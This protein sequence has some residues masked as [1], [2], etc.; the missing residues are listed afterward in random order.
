MIIRKII[1][2]LF[3]ALFSLS[4]YSQVSKQ[5]KKD[6]DQLCSKKMMGRGYSFDGDKKADKYISGQLKKMG[7]QV[8]HH[9]FTFSTNTFE[10]EME[11]IFEDK[12]LTPGEDF[13]LKPNSPSIK[14]KFKLR[15]LNA[16]QSNETLIEEIKKGKSNQI[17]VFDE[18]DINRLEAKDKNYF[19]G[20][21]N[22]LQSE[23]L[24]LCKAIIVQNCKK[25]TFS[26]SQSQAKLP[27]IQ[28][29][30]SHLKNNSVIEFD[31]KATFKKNYRSQNVFAKIEG[32]QTDSFYIFTAHYDHLGSL[33]KN[34]YF[35]GANDNAS[36]TSFLLDLAR[37]YSENKPKHSIYFI[38]FSGEE[39]GLLGSKA[40]VNDE[41]LNLDNLKFLLNFD[42]LGT[43]EDGIQ[44][45]NSTIY[46]KEY[47]VLDSINTESKLLK[48]LKRRGAA[49]NSDHCPFHNNGAKSFF[50][51]T[52]GGIQ[53]YHDVFDV[54][55]TL[56]LTEFNDVKTL[57]TKF[58]EIN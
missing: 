34:V 41:V 28:T 23:K 31:I 46:K 50:I 24:G 58:I 52:L 45:V 19:Y 22:Y 7:L 57:I 8:S 49:C 56:P 54:P 30:V 17:L 40:F 12:S 18:E 51:Y 55:E 14:G 5:V 6:I 42:L 44:I 10:N 9:G 47:A 36:G 11:I 39:I 26:A 35:P 2:L 33:G 21:L 16:N 38:F 3:I 43:G 53:A 27:F 15:L 20:F 1:T 48:R 25:L 37:Y 29:T 13:I 4:T 32:E